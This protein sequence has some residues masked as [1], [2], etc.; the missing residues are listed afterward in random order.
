[1]SRSTYRVVKKKAGKYRIA[2]KARGS[3]NAANRFLR[4]L[5]VRGLSPRTIRAYAYDLL[6]LYRWLDE[7]EKEIDQLKQAELAAFVQQQRE[8]GA[9]PNSINRRL[10]VSRL[11][12]R[13]LTGK[14]MSPGREGCFPAPYYRGR[15][16][17]RSL[18]IHVIGKSQARN[19]RVKVP[20]TLVVP[21]G[22]EEVA[23]FFSTLK[24]YRDLAIVYLMLFCGLRS[25]EV[26]TLKRADVL[27]RE[28]HV[29]VMGKGSVERVLPMPEAVMN[30]IHDYLLLERPR[31]AA[32]ECLFVVLQG[33]RRGRGM[34]PDGLRRLFRYRRE[35]RELKRANAHRFRH[36][37][38][39][40]MARAGVRLP[41][42]KELMGHAD[43]ETTLRYINL[44]MADIADEYSRAL[45]Q[46]QKRYERK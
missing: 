35:S 43:H 38:G 12:Y 31:G 17:D 4:G 1:M 45:A 42:L 25:R 22:Q 34:T 30:T 37:F 33:K 36:T 27:L 21:L 13:F 24:R 18:G 44:S 9:H 14:E 3:L 29:R 5:E 20:R 46:I 8:A 6:A 23:A 7:A 28:N 40:D 39:T 16:R 26:L 32:S 11:L 15:G 2:A 41:V 19:L 10:L